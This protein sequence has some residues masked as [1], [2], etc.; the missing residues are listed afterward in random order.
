M[1]LEPFDR[2][3]HFNHKVVF[4]RFIEDWKFVFITNK[5]QKKRVW[6]YWVGYVYNIEKIQKFG[7]DPKKHSYTEFLKQ[8]L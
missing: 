8:H 5:R 7:Y 1:K 2:V 3:Y 6:D 4:L